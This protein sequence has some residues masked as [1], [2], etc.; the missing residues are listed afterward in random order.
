MGSFSD[1]NFRSLKLC[2]HLGWTHYRNVHEKCSK[3]LF[4]Y[5]VSLPLQR[6][7]VSVFVY[8][9]SMHVHYQKMHFLDNI[10]TQ[11]FRNE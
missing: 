11:I 2:D 1:C 5:E 3:V 10:K 7:Y 6:T 9:R 4:H 8:I